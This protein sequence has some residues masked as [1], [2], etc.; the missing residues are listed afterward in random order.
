MYI[1]DQTADALPGITGSSHRKLAAEDPVTQTTGN[2][3]V[4]S[5]GSL[6]PFTGVP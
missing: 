4:R 2:Q 1:D 5:C 3:E 6:C